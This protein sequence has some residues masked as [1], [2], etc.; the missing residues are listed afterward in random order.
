MRESIAHGLRRAHG[1]R[2]GYGAELDFVAAGGFPA[3]HAAIAIETR[4]DAAI[5]LED[6]GVM[7]ASSG[8]RRLPSLPRN[9][10][11]C[12]TGPVRSATVSAEG[13]WAS[14]AT[15]NATSAAIKE[16]VLRFHRMRFLGLGGQTER[17]YFG[18]E[19]AGAARGA[20]GCE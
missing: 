9:R 15:A 12:Q 2:H 3:S 8:G 11:S 4:A 16:E 5:L 18:R 10:T 14:T 1:V 13:A 20:L 6:E 17:R 7:R 19:A